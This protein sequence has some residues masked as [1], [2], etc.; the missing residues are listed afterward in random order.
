MPSP[1]RLV[2]RGECPEMNR[3]TSK[4]PSNFP[5]EGSEPTDVT[6]LLRGWPRHETLPTF[7]RESIAVEV[8]RCSQR[9]P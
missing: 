7:P 6:G 9:W 4:R 5:D 3:R 8:S 2:A 1:H